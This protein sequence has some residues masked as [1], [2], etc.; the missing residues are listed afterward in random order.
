MENH[1]IELDTDKAEQVR[2]RSRIRTIGV[3]AEQVIFG[4][5]LRP[6]R[7]EN[8]ELTWIQKTALQQVGFLLADQL[9]GIFEPRLS[10]VCDRLEFRV[11]TNIEERRSILAEVRHAIDFRITLDKAFQ[12]EACLAVLGQTQRCGKF[13]QFFSPLQGPAAVI[14]LEYPLA[15]EIQAGNCQ[16][17]ENCGG[18]YLHGQDLVHQYTFAAITTES[19]V[20]EPLAKRAQPGP[21]PVGQR[22]HRVTTCSALFAL[23]LMSLNCVIGGTLL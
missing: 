5:R 12:A 7:R 16:T 4:D 15:A 21:Q 10:E 19:E 18:K 3:K 11:T 2:L 8:F 1:E 20:H 13:I 23:T 9:D 22:L 17:A 6:H 14:I